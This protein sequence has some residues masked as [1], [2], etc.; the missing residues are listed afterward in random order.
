MSKSSDAGPSLNVGPQSPDPQKSPAGPEGRGGSLTRDPRT[1]ATT[2][3]GAGAGYDQLVQLIEYGLAGLA[4]QLEPLRPAPTGKPLEEPVV[5][6]LTRMRT[7]L[8]APEWSGATSLSVPELN[9]PYIGEPAPP[10]SNP[11]EPGPGYAKTVPLP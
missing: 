3:A 10:V 7:A 6:A 5:A 8:A 11:P 9:V 1:P 2:G 4:A